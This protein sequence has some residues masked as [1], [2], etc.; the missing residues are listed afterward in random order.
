[1]KNRNLTPPIKDKKR[2]GAFPDLRTRLDEI[3][4]SMDIQLRFMKEYF[5]KM[6]QVSDFTVAYDS[7]LKNVESELML[8]IEKQK[9]L[10]SHE[11]AKRMLEVKSSSSSSSSSIEFEE[12]GSSS[13]SSSSS[14]IEFEEEGS[15]S[16]SSSSSSSHK[17]KRRRQRAQ[18]QVI[19]LR[20]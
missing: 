19:A 5:N 4:K 8:F 10:I 13:S 12:E 17:S 14:S 18:E 15:S 6:S 20:F 16:S 9:E 3:Y 1:M 2:Q 7:R 11:E